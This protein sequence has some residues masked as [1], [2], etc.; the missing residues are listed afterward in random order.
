[1]SGRCNTMEKLRNIF[2]GKP[3]IKKPLG[4]VGVDGSIE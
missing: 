3:E 4:N 2:V 1:M